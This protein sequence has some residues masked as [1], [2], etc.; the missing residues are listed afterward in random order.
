MAI[1]SGLES[2][3]DIGMGRAVITVAYSGPS[4]ASEAPLAV[5]HRGKGL[6]TP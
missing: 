2:A 4:L 3:V 6:E 1:S 5:R